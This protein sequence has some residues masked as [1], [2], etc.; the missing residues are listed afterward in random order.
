MSESRDSLRT[1][2]QAW[3]EDGRLYVAGGLLSAILSLVLIPVFGLLAVYCGYKI[4]D[5]QQKTVLSILMATLGGFGFLSWVITSPY[6]Q[7][8]KW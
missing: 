3:N 1:T 8:P 2:L 4:Y 5:T 7:I 6:S